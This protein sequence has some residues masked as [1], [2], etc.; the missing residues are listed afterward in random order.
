MWESQVLPMYVP[1][2]LAR[3]IVAVRVCTQYLLGH[4]DLLVDPI[5]LRSNFAFPS[6]S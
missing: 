2:Y 5:L 4:Q 3:V 1:S 6:V